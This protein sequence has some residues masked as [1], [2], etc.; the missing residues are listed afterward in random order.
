[1]TSKLALLVLTA[2]FAPLVSN[3]QDAPFTCST[4]GSEHMQ[5]FLQGHPERVAEMQQAEARLEQ[6][7]AQFAQTFDP[8]GGGDNMYVLPVVFHIIHEGGIENISD[9]QVHDA[10]RILNDDFNKLNAD[11]DNVKEE[12][13]DIVADVG[14]TFR[15][16][17]LDPEGNCTSGITRTE[18]D[19]TN[20]GG[21]DMKDLI[22][23]PRDKYL[24][25]WVCKYAQGAAGYTQTPGNVDSFWGEAADGIV[26]LHNYVGSIETG[27]VG[28]SR[29]LTHEVGHWINLR[30]TWG[31]TNDPGSPDN[32]GLTDNVSDTP[33]TQGWTSCNRNGATC[34]SPLDNVENYMEYSYCCKMFTNGQ[35]T[36]M[37]AA[38]NSGTADRNNLWT[39]G[40]LQATG[41]TDPQ[42]LCAASFT[43]DKRII[44]AGD[45]VTFEDA[46]Y[47]NPTGWSWSFPG[48]N[49]STSTEAD[50]VVVYD[51]PGQYT[52][53]LTANNASNNVSIEA[54]NHIT[55]LPSPGAPSPYAEGFDA[56]PGFT[57]AY[58]QLLNPD[59]DA[60]AFAVNPATGFN[61]APSIKMRNH[62]ITAGRNDELV[63]PPVDL[64]QAGTVDLSFWYSFA[65]RNADNDDRLRV[66]VSNDCGATWL[67]RKQLRGF[68]DLPTVPDQNAVFTPNATSQWQQAIVDNI[69]STYATA[70]FRFKLWFE[71]DGGN[72]LWID[73]INVNGVSVGLSEQLEA[74]DAA[75]MVVPN[76]A[77]DAASLLVTIAETGPTTIELLEPT[78]RVVATVAQGPVTAGAH[79][80]ELP[81]A[82]LANGLYLV[83]V[84][85]PGA[86][87][88]VRFTKE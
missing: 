9:D 69:P 26:I 49:P 21:Q 37:L 55:V 63:G 83:R 62:G 76:P 35:K 11:W 46:S 48:G 10:M 71:G 40:N 6:E 77:N 88:V 56:F 32:C 67:L 75:V 72:D 22:Q 52:V 42:V 58:W 47:H 68:T 85:Q 79:R 87:R 31:P 82:G 20:D 28:T 5:R 39:A 80:W 1:M 34:G 66:Y 41:T 30:H 27:S 3:G 60:G 78:G 36:R 57:E 54:V 4:H 18:S 19:L 29:A 7:T 84:Q 8:R 81:I 24:N 13:L 12:F 59:A 43:S 14:V 44:C 73:D 86:Q 25:I 65:R 33:P 2:A 15:L 50:P 23:W 74:A 70:N 16:A 61:A 45:A 64:S 38:L 17:G 51:T 53:Q